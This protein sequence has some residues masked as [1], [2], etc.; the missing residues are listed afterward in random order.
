MTVLHPDSID[1]NRSANPAA[2]TPGSPYG[3][4]SCGGTASPGDAPPAPPDLDRFGLGPPRSAGPPR[5]PRASSGAAI[6]P[7]VPG[8]SPRR[9]T[10]PGP[11]RPDGPPHGRSPG[12]AWPVENGSSAES[13]GEYAADETALRGRI[14]SWDS[15]RP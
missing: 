1:P 12:S 11:S 4:R 15:P 9:R 5:R 3:R 6:G 13:V 10:T 8:L 7:A 2:D 14:T